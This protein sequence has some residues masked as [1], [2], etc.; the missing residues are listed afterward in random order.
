MVHYA[1]LLWLDL[2]DGMDIV[3]NC[4]VEILSISGG[5][6]RSLSMEVLFWYENMKYENFCP[7]FKEIVIFVHLCIP[8]K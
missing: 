5:M 6:L 1:L 2:S 7:N 8:V 3:L 4:L